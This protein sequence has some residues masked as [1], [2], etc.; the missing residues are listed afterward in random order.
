MTRKQHVHVPVFAPQLSDAV[1]GVT[2]LAVGNG[3]A[4]VFSAAAAVT[5]SESGGML[6]V[7]GLIGGGLFVTTGKSAALL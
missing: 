4:D 6:A 2:L 5:A 3:A 1:A 7:A